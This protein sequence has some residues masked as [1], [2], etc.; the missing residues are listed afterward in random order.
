MSRSKAQSP[1]LAL[2]SSYAVALSV[3]AVMFIGAN[4][5]LDRAIDEQRKIPVAVELTG[6][7]SMLCQRITWLADRYTDR[8]EPLARQQLQAAITEMAVIADGRV[9]HILAK[10]VLGG[11]LEGKMEVGTVIRRR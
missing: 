8:G 4:I 9:E 6:R 5:L 2:T 11:G 10:M 7:Q 3:I 1:Y